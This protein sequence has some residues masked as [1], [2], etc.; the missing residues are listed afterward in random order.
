MTS[1]STLMLL[2][3]PTLSSCSISWSL[4]VVGN[5]FT[6]TRW[7][8]LLPDTPIKL[9][10]IHHKLISLFRTIHRFF[11]SYFMCNHAV[12]TANVVTYRKP[13]S[14][15]MDSLKNDLAAS[16]LCQKQPEDLSNLAPLLCKY[17]ATLP[18][19]INHHAPLKEK[20]LR[21]RPRVLWYNADTD[22]AKRIRR[23]AERRWRKIAVRSDYL[24]V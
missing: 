14:V 9:S 22:N 17:N 23:K 12:V 21:A 2:M 18:R 20:I 24:L 16:E 10:R 13:Q 11:A 4:L 3:T 19:M 8:S 5:M 7:I 1:I 15:D 6:D